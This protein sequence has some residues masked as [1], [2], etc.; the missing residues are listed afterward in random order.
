MLF[1]HRSFLPIVNEQQQ[2]LHYK[3]ETCLPCRGVHQT[4][5]CMHEMSGAPDSSRLAV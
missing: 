2:T 1:V 3:V 5:L 4:A